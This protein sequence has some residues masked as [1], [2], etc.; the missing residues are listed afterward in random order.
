MVGLTQGTA[1]ASETSD[2]QPPEGL[3]SAHIDLTENGID[4]FTGKTNQETASSESVDEYIEYQARNGNLVDSE[5]V[6]AMSLDDPLGEG[7]IDIVWVD[8]LTPTEVNRSKLDL[9]DDASQSGIGIA[10]AQDLASKDDTDPHP[11]GMGYS[12]AEPNGMYR[13]AYDCWSGYFD[14]FY[15]SVAGNH[16]QMVSCYEKWAES[17]TRAWA[18]N[19][20]S[21]WSKADPVIGRSATIDYTIRSRPWTGTEH[22]VTSLNSWVPTSPS[23]QC[24][25][26]GDFSLQQ[27]GVGI[28]VPIANCEDT[29]ILIDLGA[30]ELGIDW[31]GV[32]TGRQRSLDFAMHVTA[33]NTTIVPTFADYVWAEVRD[34][35]ISVCSGITAPGTYKYVHRDSGW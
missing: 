32:D 34:C 17:G 5:D 21:L 8:G 1:Q 11:V 24:S 27:G 35:G 14:P 28:T 7:S 18:Y 4:Y 15:A 10:V 25:P 3:E 9:E 30:Q 31:D 20:W 23:S 26:G 12:F 2:D 33:N 13:Q 19:R 29:A 6:R 16:H 22:A